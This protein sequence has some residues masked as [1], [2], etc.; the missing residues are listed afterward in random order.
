MKKVLQLAKPFSLRP[1]KGRLARTA[2]PFGF[3]VK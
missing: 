2:A 3:F 1:E